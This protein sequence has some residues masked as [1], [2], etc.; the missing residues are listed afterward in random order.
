MSEQRTARREIRG[1]KGMTM[2]TYT[3]TSVGIPIDTI[4][5]VDLSEAEERA[6]QRHGRSVK[7]QLARSGTASH[8][9]EL[10]ERG[11]RDYKAEMTEAYRDMG[12][13][14]ADAKAMAAMGDRGYSG[15]TTFHESTA[16]APHLDMGGDVLRQHLADAHL[17]DRALL[18]D[19]KDPTMQKAH[20]AA[21]NVNESRQV[22]A[23]H[24]GRDY[25]AEIAEAFEGM[26]FSKSDAKS[27]AEVRR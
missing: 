12:Y 7:V 1:E 13:S 10:R 27:M 21:H 2:N 19:A 8:V 11:G 22:E 18:A 24:T 15:G 25:K 26:G 14:E 9:A 6:K 16:D 20:T 17:R 23:A 4:Q 5:A 3:V